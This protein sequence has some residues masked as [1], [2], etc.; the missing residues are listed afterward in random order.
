MQVRNEKVVLTLPYPP[1]NNT[2]WRRNQGRVHI[3]REGKRYRQQVMG[4]VLE[5]LG[6]IEPLTG[7]LDM[8]IVVTPPDRRKRDLDNTLKSLLDA[9]EKAEVFADD[10]QIDDLRIL[11]GGVSPPGAVD[12][13]IS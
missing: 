10:E 11:R 5:Q 3:S 2:Y 8:E 6:R 1:S 13:Y 4:A 7:R 12:V 9:L